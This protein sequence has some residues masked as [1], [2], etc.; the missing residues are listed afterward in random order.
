MNLFSEEVERIYAQSEQVFFFF[1]FLL[2]LSLIKQNFTLAQR[3]GHFISH[4]S[5]RFKSKN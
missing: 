2:F 1:F 4:R 3:M 5:K